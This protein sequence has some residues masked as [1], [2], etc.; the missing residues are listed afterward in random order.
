MLTRV[1]VPA[2]AIRGEA[3]AGEAFTKGTWVKISGT[4]SAGDI[5]SLATGNKNIPG[6][7]SA[8]DFKVVQAVSGDTMPC[9]PVDKMT[10]VPEGADSDKDTILAGAG[11]LY[12]TEGRYE[13]DQYTSVSGTGAAYGDYL[14][15]GASGKLV[16]EDD[17]A[18]RTT[19]SVA[20]CYKVHYGDNGNHTYDRVE[21][22]MLLNKN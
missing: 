18:V 15:I 8:G 10:V 12:F 21:F 13:S 4:F 7:A 17:P 22:E 3:F 14:K 1:I 11:V 5:S 20:R 19:A 2:H 6:Y 16:E 9:F